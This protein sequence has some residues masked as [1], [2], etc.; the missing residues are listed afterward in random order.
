MLIDLYPLNFFK[1]I[2][3][4][5]RCFTNRNYLTI[6]QKVLTILF[7][8]SLLLIPVSFQQTQLTTAD[9]RNYM[10]QASQLVNNQVL[11]QIKSYDRKDYQLGI[12]EEMVITDTENEWVAF[13]EDDSDIANQIDNRLALVFVPD[14]FYLNESN[15]PSIYQ[16]YLDIAQLQEVDSSN[17]L[18]AVMSKQWYDFNR[19][20]VQLTNMLNLSLLLLTSFIILLAGATFFL[21]IMITS[22]LYTIKSVNEAFTLALN[23]YA[24]PTFIAMIVGFITADPTAM[25]TALGLMFVIMLITTYWKT[26]FNDDYVKQQIALEK[27]NDDDLII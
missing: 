1:T 5:R 23:C 7:L 3:S 2:V 13:T 6:W 16:P 15:R 12:E 4:P 9:L 11:N 20:A 18:L 17:Q 25:L 10:P 27:E 14:G 21:S 22:D 24:I 19:S 26:H 8:V